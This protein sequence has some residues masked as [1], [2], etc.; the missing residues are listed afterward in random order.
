M[1]EQC[2]ILAIR[3]DELEEEN[4]QLRA[5][6]FGPPEWKAPEEFD[7]TPGEEAVLRCLLARDRV[8]EKWLIIE[9]TRSIPSTKKDEPDAKISNVWVCKVR[10]KLKPFGL[11]IRNE[12]GV[13]YQLE[14]ETR[15]RLQNWKSQSVPRVN[16]SVAA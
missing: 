8:A 12:W 9:A 15:A 10:A 3:N 13:G 1:C 16:S 11:K 4:H 7:L 2:V 5:H 6:V 14:P